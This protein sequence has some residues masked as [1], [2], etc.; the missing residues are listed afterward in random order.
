MNRPLRTCSAR[1]LERRKPSLLEK[2]GGLL[3][4]GV[5]LLVY[6][7]GRHGQTGLESPDRTWYDHVRLVPRAL[8]PS[9]LLASVHFVRR[10]PSRYLRALWSLLRLEH[11]PR[12]LVLRAPAL[13][14]RAAWIASEVERSGGC[15]LQVSP[16]AHEQRADALER[17]ITDPEV[18][19]RLA[20]AACARAHSA[21]AFDVSSARL[22]S[23]FGR[24][25]LR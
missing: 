7:V 6:A 17:V 13:F 1:S 19:D 4:R 21:F 20:S 25:V 22:A 15:R 9:V 5:P 11:R 14:L 24:Q 3:R 10:H 2:Y 12:L 8:A 16:D 18:A 23:L